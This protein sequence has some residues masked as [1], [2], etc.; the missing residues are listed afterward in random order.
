MKRILTLIL[1]L[2]LVG[3][4][5]IGNRQTNTTTNQTVIYQGEVPVMVLD[6]DGVHYISVNDAP[7]DLLIERGLLRLQTGEVVKAE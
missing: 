4:M 6:Y 1:L 3:C 5:G 7:Q 2:G